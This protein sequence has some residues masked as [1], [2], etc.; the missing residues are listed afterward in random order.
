MF[1]GLPVTAAGVA[2]AT[3][4]VTIFHTFWSNGITLIGLLCLTLAQLTF[5]LWSDHKFLVD[6]LFG[7]VAAF[8]AL[9][10]SL[11]VTGQSGKQG[12][13]LFWVSALLL[14]GGVS[15]S[16]WYRVAQISVSPLVE[17]TIHEARLLLLA[18][19]VMAV[20]GAIGALG[21]RGHRRWAPFAF[22]LVIVGGGLS[23]AMIQLSLDLNA[24]TRAAQWPE[25][26]A[27]WNRCFSGDLVARA[28]SWSWGWP[29]VI[30]PLLA[31]GLW[32]LLARGCR[33]RRAGETPVDLEL[34]VFAIGLLAILIPSSSTSSP[35]IGLL[36][37]ASVLPLFG[38]AD[39]VKL[40][41]E[42]LKLAPP[43][44]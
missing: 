1:T 43:S 31:I 30:A 25:L 5:N 44:S 20:G 42:Q 32:R 29:E 8:A 36:W 7:H 22:M 15:G 2:M 11:V 28:E 9:S 16:A 33:Q 18:L 35:S 23:Y 4:G 19:G 38:V 40:L 21:G 27:D 14:A 37:A 3:I 26:M 6:P 24:I 13:G 34:F 39:L 41:F 12:N 10:L 17:Q